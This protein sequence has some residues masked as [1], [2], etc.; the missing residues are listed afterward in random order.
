MVFAHLEELN[1][2]FNNVEFQQNLYYSAKQLPRLHT[3]VISGNPFAI[4][5]V[6]ENYK[7]LQKLMDRREGVL[8]NETL[9]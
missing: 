8:I 4:T 5:G 9:K 6:E 1:F 7:I 3:L 2:S